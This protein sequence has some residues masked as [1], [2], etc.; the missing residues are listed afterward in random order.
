MNLIKLSECLMIKRDF[1]KGS[2]VFVNFNLT[3]FDFTLLT[4]LAFNSK[5]K[6][7]DE[8]QLF[9]FPVFI[10]DSKTKF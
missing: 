1:H 7:N 3:W 10:E 2:P 8:T 9:D 6:V 4:T 5:T